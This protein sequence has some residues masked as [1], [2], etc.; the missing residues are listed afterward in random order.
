MDSSLNA[1][2]LFVDNLHALRI[3]DPQVSH[4]T[5]DLKD[6]SRFYAESKYK[7]V[8]IHL[9]GTFTHLVPCRTG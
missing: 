4:D 5:V 1:N 6:E 8:F 7:G 2:G 9:V 3:I